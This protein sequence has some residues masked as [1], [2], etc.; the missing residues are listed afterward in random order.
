M[1]RNKYTE[2]ERDA[3]LRTFIR[4]AREIIDTEGL[5]QVSARK[6]A[7]LTGFNSAKL[8]SYFKNLDDLVAMAS[9]SYLEK[10]ISLLAH[11]IPHIKTHTAF[12]FHSWEAF[13]RCALDE[14]EIYY[15]I[16]CSRHEQT[17]NDLMEEYY[18]LYPA[19][20]DELEEKVSKM[21]RNADLRQRN[22]MCLEPLAAEGIIKQE[23]I[24]YINDFIISY[25]KSILEER[26]AGDRSL[27]EENEL[28][29]RFMGA[30]DVILG[31]DRGWNGPRV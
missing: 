30:L 19:Q 20:L 26:I 1:G 6:L 3:I 27:T 28:A 11:D 5:E 18:R 21:F 15:R 14:P 9:I 31:L 24:K 4:A 13:C 7:K 16:F 2:E 8:Y 25:F 29:C 23:H 10:Y 12:F 17:Y 22:M